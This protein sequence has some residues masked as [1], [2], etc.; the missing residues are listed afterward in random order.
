MTCKKD[1]GMGLCMFNFVF[2]V[3]TP[4]FAYCHAYIHLVWIL[5][6]I[7]IPT[8]FCI[9]LKCF[10]LTC[11]TVYYCALLA[12][13]VQRT[14]WSYWPVHSLSP[15]PYPFPLNFP[16][17]HVFPCPDLSRQISEERDAHMKEAMELEREMKEL[18]RQTE[19]SPPFPTSLTLVTS[20][21][22]PT[23]IEMTEKVTLSR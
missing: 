15:L 20:T 23:P 21:P 16:F 18:R 12:K 14:D 17:L 1:V 22:A 3:I 10:F 13:S 4:A 9:F 8:Y 5:F 19:G 7:V 2:Y 11:R 6:G